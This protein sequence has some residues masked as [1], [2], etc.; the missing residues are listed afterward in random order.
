MFLHPLNYCKSLLIQYGY[1]ALFG[2]LTLGIL[3]VPMPDEFLL[4]FAG[5][6]CSKSQHFTPEP[7][8]LPLIILAGTMGS[9]VGITGSYAIGRFLGLPALHRFGRWLHVTEKNIQTVHNW[10]ERYGKW[11]LTFGYFIPG[12]RH[13]T[14]ILSGATSLPLHIFSLFAYLGALLWSSTF[15]LIGY[16]LGPKTEWIYLHFIHHYQKRISLVVL[17]MVAAAAII[18]WYFSGKGVKEEQAKAQEK[19]PPTDSADGV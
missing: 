17:G 11:P 10:F 12:F 16:F 2:T 5:F 13:L 3:G 6:L 1:F 15:I 9:I 18:W 4:M 19:T 7:L 8:H 14:A